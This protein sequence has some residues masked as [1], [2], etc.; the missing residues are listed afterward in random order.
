MVRMVLR[1]NCSSRS[2]VDLLVNT[3]LLNR[4]AVL[5]FLLDHG[6]GVDHVITTHLHGRLPA[7]G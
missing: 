5:T 6:P 3:Y 7:E 2:Q 4:P 1:C